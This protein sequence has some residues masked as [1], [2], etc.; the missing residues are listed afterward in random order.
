MHGFRGIFD[1]RRQNIFHH[2]LLERIVENLQSASCPE[3][4]VAIFR[5]LSAPLKFS[6][7]K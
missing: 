5:S 2:L 6:D 1:N 4:N 3:T 7:S